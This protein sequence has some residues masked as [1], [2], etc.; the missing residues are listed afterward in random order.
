MRL[1]EAIRE[2]I[3]RAPR[4]TFRCWSDG[5]GGACAFAT[6]CIGIGT[7]K[8]RARV[9]EIFG[10]SIRDLTKGVDIDVVNTFVK[11]PVT[12]ATDTLLQAVTSLNDDHSWTREKIAAWLE[13]CGL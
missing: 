11:H 2:G 5:R 8:S 12:C 6:A 9:G 7:L 10:H 13:E 4:Q 3:K 1:S